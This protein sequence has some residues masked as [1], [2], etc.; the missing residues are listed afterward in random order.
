MFNQF[1]PENQSKNDIQ[2]RIGALSLVGY[3][4]KGR[5]KELRTSPRMKWVHAGW[6]DTHESRRGLFYYLESQPQG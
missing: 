2:K 5:T 1:S 6:Q 4:F 3:V